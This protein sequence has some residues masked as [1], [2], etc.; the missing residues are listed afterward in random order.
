[1]LEIDAKRFWSQVERCGA[2]DCWPWR[3]ALSPSGYGTFC[4]NGRTYRATHVSLMLKGKRRPSPKHGACHTCDNPACV[5]P[6]HLWWGTQSENMLDA[7]AK[8]RLPHANKTHCPHGHELSPDNIVVNSK[9]GRECL[10]CNRHQAKLRGRRWR[11]RKS[12]AL[13][14]PRIDELLLA[15]EIRSRAMTEGVPDAN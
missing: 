4:A 13:T 9:G 8:R 12:A 6:A 2:D 1:M 5:N 14:V 7:S 11:E 10:T 3:S 15:E